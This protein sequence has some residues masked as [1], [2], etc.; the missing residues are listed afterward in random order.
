ML[1]CVYYFCLPRDAK[2]LYVVFWTVC[3]LFALSTQLNF[4]HIAFFKRRCYEELYRADVSPTNVKN[5][6]RNF[7]LQFERV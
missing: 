6:F 4:F 7:S 5:N 3:V 1:S 2:V